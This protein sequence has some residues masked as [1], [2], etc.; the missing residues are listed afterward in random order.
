MPNDHVDLFRAER[1]RCATN[2]SNQ[3]QT[4]QFVQHLGPR[5]LHSGSQSGGKNEYVKRLIGLARLQ[6]RSLSPWVLGSMGYAG[7]AGCEQ[8]CCL[9]AITTRGQKCGVVSHLFTVFEKIGA[10]DLS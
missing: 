1:L 10:N 4:A 6:K 9:H 7:T 8:A 2:V 5:G 3:R